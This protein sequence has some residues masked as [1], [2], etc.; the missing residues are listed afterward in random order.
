MQNGSAWIDLLLYNH[1]SFADPIV[2]CNITVTLPLHLA[3]RLRGATVRRIDE[4]HSNPLASWIA[5]GAPDYTTNAQNAAL[6]AASELITEVR[7]KLPL[8]CSGFSSSCTATLKPEESRCGR[9]LRGSRKCASLVL[10]YWC[11]RMVSLL[12]VY[13]LGSRQTWH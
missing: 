3:I 8:P 4:T 6:L 11:Q 13:P 10:R 7:L 12:Y 9:T 1:A 2:D 5:M